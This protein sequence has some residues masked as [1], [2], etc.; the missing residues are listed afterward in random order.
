[1]TATDEREAFP[2]GLDFEADAALIRQC[3][4]SVRAATATAVAWRKKMVVSAVMELL[5]SFGVLVD[6]AAGDECDQRGET[7]RN[8]PGCQRTPWSSTSWSERSQGP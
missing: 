6:A 2:V 8:P 5:S 1:M 7:S 3:L 4:R